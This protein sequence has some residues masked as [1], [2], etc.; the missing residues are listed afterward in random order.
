VRRAWVGYGI[1]CLALAASAQA[2][3]PTFPQR[4]DGEVNVVVDEAGLLRSGDVARINVVARELRADK[5]VPIIVVTIRSLASHN[6]GRSSINRYATA[7]FD[8]WGIGFEEHNYGMLLLVAKADRRARIELGAGWGREHDHEARE[9]MQ[10][11]IVPAFKEGEF[12]EGI[13]RGVE[14][15]DAMARGEGIPGPPRPWWWWPLWI[16][17]AALACGVVYSLITQGIDGWGYKLLL[18][19]CVA[20]GTIIIVA[21]AGVGRA[22]SSGGGSFGGGFSGGGGATGSW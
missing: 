18:G 21:L 8:E 1:V 17:L 20:I 5:Q 6:A 10:G 19:L 7:L 2:A 3:E 14:G 11:L 13:L 9:V 4:P 22:G 12:S 16:G 15:M